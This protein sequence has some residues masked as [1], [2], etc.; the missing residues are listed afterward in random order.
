MPNVP[1]VVICYS[2]VYSVVEES[3]KNRR[4]PTERVVLGIDPGTTVMGFGA[5]RI[6]GNTLSLLGVGELRMKK[7][8][9][10]TLRLKEIF[11]R[12]LELIDTYH[13]DDMAIEAQFFGKNVQSMLKLGRAQGV[14]IGAALHRDLAVMEYAP[15]KIKQSVTGNGNASKEQVAAMVRTL[16]NLGTQKV[17]LDATDALAVAIC[18]NFQSSGVS[19]QKGQYSGWEAYLNKNPDR[20]L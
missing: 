2:L 10:M 13:P 12:T 7:G 3:R 8:S 19:T 11:D 6:E 16:V 15:R 4:K 14:C 17:T 9:D 5:I 18:H 20:A 1:R